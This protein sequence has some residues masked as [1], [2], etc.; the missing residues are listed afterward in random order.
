MSSLCRGVPREGRSHMMSADLRGVLNMR[1]SS[2]RGENTPL[3]PSGRGFM[4]VKEEGGEKVCD[5]C[6]VAVACFGEMMLNRGD[7]EIGSRSTSAKKSFTGERNDV[8]RRSR[9]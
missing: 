2:F 7:S 8:S 1:P 5:V 9:L 3:S 6:E 4:G